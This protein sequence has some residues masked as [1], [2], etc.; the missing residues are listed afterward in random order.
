MSIGPEYQT[1]DEVAE[2]ILKPVED[3]LAKEAEELKKADEII[4]E[5]ERQAKP[6]LDPE[7]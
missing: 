1:D 6:I 2:E 4:R 7:L 3:I 5:A